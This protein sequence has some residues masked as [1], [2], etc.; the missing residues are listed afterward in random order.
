MV[1]GRAEAVEDAPAKLAALERFIEGL[2]PGRW[3]ALRAPTRKEMNATTVLRLPIEEASAK[4]R[5][6]PPADQE[7]DLDHPVWAGVLPLGVRSG[8]PTPCEHNADG[9]VSPDYLDSL[10]IG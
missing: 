1:F 10:K 9:L 2:F 3:D 8:D 6:G 4:V 5:T 7:S